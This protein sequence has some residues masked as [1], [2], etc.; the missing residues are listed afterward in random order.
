MLLE[1][2]QTT[3]CIDAHDAVSAGHKPKLIDNVLNPKRTRKKNIHDTGTGPK[4]RCME[5]TWL[6]SCLGAISTEPFYMPCART[7]C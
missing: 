6:I 2:V 7:N 5:L 4:F 3:R 1:D